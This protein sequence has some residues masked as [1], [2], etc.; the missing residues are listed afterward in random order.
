MCLKNIYI[1]VTFVNSSL[2]HNNTLAHS[3]VFKI[4]FFFYAT[5]TLHVLYFVKRL[6]IRRERYGW[7]LHESSTRK[8]N[9][10]MC[11]VH[12]CTMYTWSSNVCG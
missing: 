1:G 3:A 10:R 4:T 8:V 7:K 5:L 12:V 2:Q 11:T 9:I 6:D